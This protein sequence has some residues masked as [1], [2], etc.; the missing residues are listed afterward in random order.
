MNNTAPIFAKRLTQSMYVGALFLIVVLGTSM[1]ASADV[2][3]AKRILKSMSNYLAAQDSLSFDYDATLEIV[4]FDG[5]KLALASS[6][7]LS[8]TRPD[9]LYVTR[10][11]GFA[12]TA[13][14]FDGKTLTI[15]GMNENLY[16]QVDI[17]GNIDNLVD[18]FRLSISYKIRSL[19]ISA[20]SI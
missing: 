15:L 13:T 20:S 6:G 10:A 18:T 8:M 5:Q 16:T 12:D 2:S 3:D 17:P 11:G 4:T 19:L 1:P 14:S 9:Q 7:A